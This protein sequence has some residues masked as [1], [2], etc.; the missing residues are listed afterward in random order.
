VDMLA[1]RQAEVKAETAG[2]TL[3]NVEGYY[4]LIRWLRGY[5]KWSPR[6]ESTQ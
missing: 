6:H 3:F 1:E 4:C 5:H 2:N